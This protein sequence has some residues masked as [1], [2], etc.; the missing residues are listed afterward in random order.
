MGSFPVRQEITVIAADPEGK[1]LIGWYN[2][3]C[4][5][6]GYFWIYRRERIPRSLRRHMRKCKDCRDEYCP[7]GCLAIWE[8]KPENNSI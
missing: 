5:N 1:R 8:E 7:S 2:W 3:H 6:G 4:K